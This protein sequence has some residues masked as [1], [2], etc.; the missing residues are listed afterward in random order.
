ML[1]QRFDDGDRISEERSQTPDDKPFQI[2]RRN[3]LAGGLAI[4]FFT[5]CPGDEAARHIVTFPSAASQLIAVS[6]SSEIRRTSAALTTATEH[7]AWFSP[8][9]LCLPVTASSRCDHR[10]GFASFKKRL[11]TG[12]QLVDSP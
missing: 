5:P 6:R 3:A 1:R 11:V 8:L 12:L 9:F 4:S 10:H 7:V 2:G